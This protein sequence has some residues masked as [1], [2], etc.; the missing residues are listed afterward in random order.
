MYKRQ[1]VVGNK[2]QFVVS[3]LVINVTETIVFERTMTREEATWRSPDGRKCREGEGN[4]RTW[5]EGSLD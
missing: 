1:A 5:A 3:L 2:K 4:S